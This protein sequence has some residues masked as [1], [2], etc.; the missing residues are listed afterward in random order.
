MKIGVRIQSRIEIAD[1]SDADGEDYDI[2]E[3]ESYTG[4]DDP[5][6]VF[7][8]RRVR[9]KTKGSCWLRQVVDRLDFDKTVQNDTDVFLT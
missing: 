5:Q 9:L 7:M 6:A 1:A 3:E 8:F 4:D 2:W